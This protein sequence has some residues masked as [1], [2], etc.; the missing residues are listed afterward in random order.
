MKKLLIIILLFFTSCNYNLGD[1][2][3]ITAENFEQK[4]NESV[5]IKEKYILENTALIREVKSNPKDRIEVVV[6]NKERISNELFGAEEVFEPSVEIRRWDE[7]GFKITP[8]DYKD[9]EERTLKFEG[10][11]IKIE[12]PQK[13][14]IMYELPV[15]E[16]LPEGGFEYQ[17]DLKEKP[18]SNVIS[19]E[20]ETDGLDFFYQPELTEEEIKEDAFRPENVIGSYAVY[21]SEEKINWVGGKEYKVGKVGHIYRPKIVDSK[22]W[23]VWGELK[24][25]KDILSVTIPQDFLDKAVYPIRHASGLTFGYDTKGGSVD[26]NQVRGNPYLTVTGNGGN[27]TKITV[28][29]K[30]NSGLAS[31]TVNAGLWNV[32]ESHKPTTNVGSG[33]DVTVNINF[34][35]WKDITTDIVFSGS[36]EYAL[37]VEQSTSLNSALYFYDANTQD[38]DY[39]YGKATG[40]SYPDFGDD[41]KINTLSGDYGFSIYA[42]YTAPT[43]EGSLKIK[44]GTLQIKNGNLQIK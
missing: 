34:E 12:T 25:E 43:P 2:K 11:K 13:D 19:F 44:S 23:E 21:T 8:S 31:Y 9:I 5:Y 20:L 41:P 14:F 42:T 7:V 39:Y 15:S 37:A 32:D 36:T 38:I 26:S 4:Y 24:I 33:T 10:D 27:I 40:F 3:I 16:D 17:I 1:T 29:Q 30:E 18:K 22:G 6:G 28:A 35:G